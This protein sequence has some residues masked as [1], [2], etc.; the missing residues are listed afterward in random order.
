MSNERYETGKA[1]LVVFEECAG[2][3]VVRGWAENA[4]VVKGA[5]AAEEAEDS[6]GVRAAGSLKVM[7]PFQSRLVLRSIAGDVIIKSVDGEVE[8]GE[9]MGDA[10]LKMVGAVVAGTVHGDAG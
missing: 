2:D 7:V 4:V 5:H 10:N 1:P 8:V 6:L 3:L 9:A